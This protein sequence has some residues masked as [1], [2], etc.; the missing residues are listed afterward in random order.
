MKTHHLVLTIPPIF[1][2][3]F[4]RFTMNFPHETVNY[5]PDSAENVR[6]PTDDRFRNK[7]PNTKAIRARIR[8]M[9]LRKTEKA[10]CF[11]YYV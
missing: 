1:F 11:N 4:P 2:D 9:Q 10:A 6:L 8:F 5:P 3:D 7:K